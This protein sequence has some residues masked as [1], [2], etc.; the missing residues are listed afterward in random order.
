MYGKLAKL[1]YKRKNFWS[2]KD[3]DPED[4]CNDSKKQKLTLIFGNIFL[5][6]LYSAYFC[7][8]LAYLLFGKLG[9]WVPE[10]HPIIASALSVYVITWGIFSVSGTGIFNLLIVS[11]CVEVQ[12]QFQLI[13]YSLSKMEI[14]LQGNNRKEKNRAA[15]REIKKIVQHHTFL[16]E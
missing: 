4:T 1:Y 12:V 11:L 9:I 8:I 16:L 3:I 10:S 6:L 2:L 15:V 13:N 14:S 5:I 7:Y